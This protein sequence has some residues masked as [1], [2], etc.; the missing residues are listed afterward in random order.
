MSSGLLLILPRVIR[1]MHAPGYLGIDRNK[2]DAEVRPTLTEIPLG[3]RAIGYDRLELDAWADAYIAARG[4]PGRTKKGGAECAPGREESFS[5]MTERG[6]SISNTAARGSLSG[7]AKSP[8][9]TPKHGSASGKPKSTPS[10]K[11]NFEAAM[12]GCSRL[13]HEST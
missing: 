5:L 6:S 7:L 2:F 3:K 11:T 8:K 10:A 1:Q 4:R 13:L 9:T 12:N